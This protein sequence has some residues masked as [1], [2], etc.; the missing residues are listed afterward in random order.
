MPAAILKDPDVL[1][2]YLDNVCMFTT[3]KESLDE[4]MQER[5]LSLAAGAEPAPGLSR[6]ELLDA[7]DG[8]RP[9]PIAD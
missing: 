5:V 2:V 3:R 9:E 8:V 4:E 6:K 7:L 1:L